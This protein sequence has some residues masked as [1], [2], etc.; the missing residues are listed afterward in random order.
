MRAGQHHMIGV[1][2]DGAPCQRVPVR[3]E[4]QLR[5]IE[6]GMMVRASGYWLIKARFSENF[7]DIII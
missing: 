2:V 3:G 5:A 6:C 4:D 7:I 1:G